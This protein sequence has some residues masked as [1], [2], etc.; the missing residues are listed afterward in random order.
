[1]SARA[2]LKKAGDPSAPPRPTVIDVAPIEPA[3]PAKPAA[4]PKPVAKPT[5]PPKHVAPPA[6]SSVAPAVASK[7]IAP[8]AVASPT[9]VASTSDAP[10]S[11]RPPAPSPTIVVET[12]PSF[13]DV[14]INLDVTNRVEQLEEGWEGET[15]I[16]DEAPAH[17]G[18]PPMPAS[19]APSFVAPQGSQPH[20]RP[21]QPQNGHPVASQTA[22]PAPPQAS[23]SSQSASTQ[24]ASPQTASSRTA[25]SSAQT[26]SARTASSSVQTGSSRTASSSAQTAS[27]Q[28]AWSDSQP[29]W[30]DSQPAWSESQPAWSESAQ[31]GWS[32]SAQ[33]ARSES[34]QPAWSESPQSAWSPSQPPAWSESPQA[35]PATHDS[36][37][38]Q[39]STHDAAQTQPSMS[40]ALIPDNLRRKS[41][42]RKAKPQPQ[43]QLAEPAPQLA[44]VAKPAEDAPPVRFS[45]NKL[46]AIG[47]GVAALAVG[48]VAVAMIVGGGKDTSVKDAL[49]RVSTG[50]NTGTGFLI[51]GPDQYTY[52]AT[53]NHLVDRGER[54]LVERDVAVSD[55][56]HY[57]EAYP[58][59]EIVATDPDADLA[60]IRIKNVEA[61]RFARLPLAKEPVKDAKIFSY[62]YPGSSL[63]KK[64]GLVSKDG[65]IL[66][67][68]RF[69]A[70]DDR[71][72]RVLREN[73]VDGL[74][75]STDIEPGFSGGPTTNEAGE[76]VGINVTKD[77]AHVG[78]NGAVSVAALRDLM[79]KVKPASAPTEPKSE[80]IVALLKKVQSEYLLLPIEERSRV[81]EQDFLAASDLPAVRRFVNE[82][83]REE[84]NTDNAFIAKLRLSG[85]AALGM[86]FARLPGNLLETYRATSTKSAIMSCALA[87]QRL[88]SFFGELDTS[89]RRNQRSDAAIDTCDALGVRPL[90]WD[91][92]AATLQWDG[93]EKEYSVTKIDRMDDDGRI[94]RASV[95]ISGASNL[96]ELWFGIEQGAPRLKLFDTTENLYAI[97]SPRTVS[98]A[99]LQGTWQ[100]KRPRVTDAV[101]K[102]AEVESEEKVSISIGEEN[103]VSILFT[104]TQK[105]FAVSKRSSFACSRK[106]TMEVGLAQSFVGT[107]ENGVVI[108]TPEKVAS[109]VGA[110]SSYCTARRLP[111][112]IVA[113]KLVG[114]QLFLYRTDGLAYPETVQLTKI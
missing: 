28:P 55:K 48:G 75:V 111:D 20:H 93:K 100:M 10:T 15:E 36:A 13:E 23:A 60:I 4:P 63:A 21:G 42:P 53:A 17:L 97:D 108:G 40:L 38:T 14:H 56:K 33:Q 77:R 52:V 61:K 9:P 47:A 58:E 8:P 39:A 29:A 105:Y 41:E 54:I 83:R 37:Q 1:M 50:G 24:S 106:G 44:P 59:T 7:P 113:V 30:S 82:I 85:Q 78:Q 81:R 87:N 84:R 65:K 72:S 46:I 112:Q 76:V 71:Y 79:K 11:A 69:P 73:A 35:Q 49:V 26:G 107:L 92:A 114:D 67:I 18:P 43:P 80:D 101:D 96:V 27:A 22:W 64:A 109:P 45:R 31:P 90:A 12:K 3:K 25:S 6:P 95:R 88:A 34:A 99:A 94:Y 57:V 74:L 68:V 2:V 91:L 102:D 89:K 66:S 110:D 103:R 104:T 51:D 19:G 70:Y 62:G 98:K 86:Y 5:A 32:E 16:H